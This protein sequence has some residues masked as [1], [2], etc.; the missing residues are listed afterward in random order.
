MMVKTL[1]NSPFEVVSSCFSVSLVFRRSGSSFPQSPSLPF[2]SSQAPSPNQ[3]ISQDEAKHVL[4][5][6]RIHQHE[7]ILIYPDQAHAP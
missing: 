2:L 1:S 4:S 7:P 5:Q 6:A 3:L